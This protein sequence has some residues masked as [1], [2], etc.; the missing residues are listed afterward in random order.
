MTRPTIDEQ[1]LRV[2]AE[3]PSRHIKGVIAERCVGF[4]RRLAEE[5]RDRTANGGKT[6]YLEIGVRLGHSLAIVA[7]AAADG[8]ERAVGIDSYVDAYAGED[9]PG[10]EAVSE[11][12]WNFGLPKPPHSDIVL[13]TGDSH[14]LLPQL[15]DEGDLVFNLAL[16]D[17]D[18]TTVGARRDLDDAFELLEVG[19]T[20]VF[21][22]TY[23]LDAGARGPHVDAG[24]LDVWREFAIGNR[25]VTACGEELNDEVPWCWLM[26]GGG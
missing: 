20:L 18:H 9:N 17:G 26:K 12:L 1:W 15:L 13:Y 7:L 5:A 25:R 22:D 2:V 8:L 6:R 3:I 11:H 10:A 16:V 14:E 19:G 23:P 4:R 24:L 21:D